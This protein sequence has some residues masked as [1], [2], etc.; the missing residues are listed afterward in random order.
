MKI[1]QTYARIGVERTPSRLEMDSA[2]SEIRFRQKHARIRVRTELPR[3]RIDQYECFAT[4]GLKNNGDRA[5]EITRMAYKKAMEYIAKVAGDGDALAAIEKGGNP[6]AEIAQ[7][8]SF[9]THEFN[10]VAMPGARPKITVEGGVRVE[11]AGNS[12]GV[13][14]GVEGEYRRGHL[15]IAFRPSVV[16]IY[17]AQKNSI[18]FSYEDDNINLRL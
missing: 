9:T 17:M 13:W 8:D 6:V 2:R 3:V 1:A 10:I 7:R 14:N 12:E 5:E 11:S 15:N 18:S 4:A 16:R